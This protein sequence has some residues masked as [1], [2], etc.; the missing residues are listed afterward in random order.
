MGGEYFYRTIPQMAAALVE[1]LTINHPFESGNKRT[2][3]L[4]MQVFLHRNGY[5]M[6]ATDDEKVEFME[7]VAMHTI[8]FDEMVGW[9]EEHSECIEPDRARVP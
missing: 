8:S 5:V 4:A 9:I 1:A 2:A 3:L 7:Q 6:I